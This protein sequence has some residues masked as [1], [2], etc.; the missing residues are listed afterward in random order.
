MSRKIS[1]VISRGE[2]SAFVPFERV[3]NSIFNIRW[4]KK[5]EV[6]K[7]GYIN[8]E[9]DEWEY[10]GEIRDTNYCTY[11]MTRWYGELNGFKF[12]NK[13]LSIAS[14][15][16]SI[17]ELNYILSELGLQEEEKVHLMKEYLLKKI[18]VYDSS[19]EVNRFFIGEYPT[20]LDKATRVGL[21]LRFDAEL[22]TGLES[23]ILWQNGISF[24]LPLVGDGNAFQMLNAIELYASACYDNTQKH[25]SVVKILTTIDEMINYDYTAGYPEKLRFGF[26][27]NIIES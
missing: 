16:A 17:E 14:R 7:V 18:A 11:E 19:D 22:A 4:G 23:T 5:D 24:P 3:T 25:I 21:K 10:T 15:E 8:E 20:W 6:E 2:K 12:I 27:E 26:R 13:I 1:T 9:T